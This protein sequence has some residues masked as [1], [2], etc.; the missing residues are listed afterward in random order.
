MLNI[1]N[2]RM[3]LGMTQEDFAKAVNVSQG[4]VSQWEI[5]LTRPGLR[6]MVRIAH[7]MGVTVEELLNECA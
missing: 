2:L 7:L 6:A 3:R 1:R 5:G 4:A